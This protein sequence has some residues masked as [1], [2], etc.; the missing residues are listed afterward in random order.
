[1]CFNV[2]SRKDGAQFILEGDIEGCFDNINHEWMLNNISLD[3]KML[4]Q[5]LKAGVIENKIL[6]PTK[7]GT[8]Q[9]GII[10]PILANMV[11]DGLEAEIN[12]TV[13]IYYKNGKK[14]GTSTKVNFIRYA[15]DFIVT[16]VSS[17]ILQEKIKPV[18]EVFLAERGLKLSEQKTRLTHI[19]TG[20][21][22]LGQ[23]IRKY[24]GKLLIK[25]SK[26]SIMSVRKKIQKLIR[27]NRAMA[28]SN[29][30]NRLN[31]IIRGWANYHKHVVSKKVF[32]RLDHEIF[33]MLWKWAL[34]RHPRKGRRWV[35]AR[36]YKR[37]GNRDWVFF[38]IE[39]GVQVELFKMDTTKIE[40]HVM[41]KRHA[42]PYDSEWEEYFEKRIDRIMVCALHG[43]NLLTS[44]WKSQKG[45]CPVCNS[46]ITVSTKWNTHHITPKHL[47]GEYK[48]ANLVM[49]HPD[50]HRQV[51]SLNIKVN[52]PC[53]SK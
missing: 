15:D 35:K 36:Y 3:K 43:Y 48:S 18:I 26:A 12:K 10:S 8:P 16:G 37:K 32:S 39:N 1:M 45:I 24:K 2:V 4:K 44:L 47:G 52:K 5:W 38:A 25:P 34:M 9:G 41:I 7:T 17:E 30:I 53:Y 28:T 33:L 42:N 13:G 27:G 14:Q 50:C 29:L 40:R 11:L 31:P 20:F 22:F 6:F 23:N 51:H 19:E 46:K 49:L 21:N